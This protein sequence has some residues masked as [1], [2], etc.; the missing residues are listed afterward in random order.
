LPDA[1][2][3]ISILLIHAGW[4]DASKEKW[5]VRER[6]NFPAR[7][8]H[9]FPRLLSFPGPSYLAGLTTNS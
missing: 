7:V 6:D 9:V 5:L 3:C 2:V 8:E 1:V 4:F